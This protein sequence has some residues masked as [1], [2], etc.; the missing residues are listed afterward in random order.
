MRFNKIVI[1]LITSL[2]VSFTSYSQNAN[3][4]GFVYE[5][6]SG[7]PVIFTNVYLLGTTIG[8]S[9][10]VNGYFSITKVS[11]GKYTLTV[12]SIGFDTIKMPVEIT[13][14]EIVTKKLFIAK[15]AVSL[16]DVVIS[17]EKQDA[18]TQV[19][20]S[21]TK[22]TPKEI[23]QLPSVGGEPDLAQY[24]QVVP[25]VVFTGDQGGQLYIRGGSPVQNKVLLDG[26]I[27]YNPFHSIGLFSVFDADIIRNADVYTGGFGAQYGGRISSIMDITTRDGNKNRL[28]GKVS[29][30]TFGAKVL[31][32]GPIVKQKEEG[33]GSSSFIVSLK[34]SYLNQTS[35]S[36]YSYI[37]T[38][39]LPYKFTDLYGKI[40]LNAA[41]GSK[42]NLFGFNFSDKV[43]YRLVSDLHWK[44]SGVGSNFVL[45]PNNSSVLVKGNFSYSKYGISLAEAD[46]LPRSSDINGFNLGL[47][48][49]YFLGKNDLTYG[50][51]VLGYKTQFD[52]YNSL[53]RH[54]AQVDNTT[55][56]AAYIKTKLIFG[57]LILEPSVRLHYYA[58]LPVFSP[59]PRL[60]AKLNATDKF[61]I[62]F[63]GGLYSQN[64]MSAASDRDVVN[65]FYGF[66][67][68]PDNLQST[69]T[70]QNG[71]TRDVKN[72]LQKSTH[73]I[74]GFEYDL[75]KHITMNIEGYLKQFGQLT[76][77][78]KNK[79]YDDDAENSSKPDIQK[80]D[81]IVESGSAKGADISLKYEH[82]HLYLWA[83]Y[84]LT[85][86]NRWDGFVE[87]QPH[88]D[89]RHNVNLVG[90]YTFGK[91]LHW[92]LDARWNMGSGFP[93]YKTTGFY[94]KIYFKDGVGTDYTNENGD[95]TFL[96][97][98]VN[99]GR[100]PYYHRLDI[101]VKRKFE[102]S[103]NATLEANAGVTNVYNRKNIFYQDRIT[104]QRVNQLPFLPSLGLNLLF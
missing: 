68:S 65:L 86:V 96:L 98:P 62:K 5:K 94:E 44:E 72:G 77:I 102:L 81:F 56:A 42:F 76:N 12:T 35:K 2:F 83:V 40:S 34:N 7:E 19:R 17:A 55:E 59:E 43:N 85:F 28:A 50:I 104:N 47:D 67:S 36:L 29:A 27:I 61:R 41:N 103:T 60:G 53:G 20:T 88:F 63:A 3:I 95:L 75:S 1:L 33:G 9:T 84:S 73:Y 92:E 6:A 101:T 25:G 4:R 14:D 15:S 46:G 54:I 93:F 18:V 11:P 79:I 74:L 31:L 48:F 21:V 13:A 80:K 66:L 52:F 97:E 16:K 32:E 99:T 100:L 8:A 37:D 58:S 38:N 70:K 87:Y 71:K 10:D 90:S 89:R 82:R 64:L 24:L 45:I 22:I 78:N 91:G 26:M 30:T 51:E 39:G 23:K 69:F 57:K 49:T